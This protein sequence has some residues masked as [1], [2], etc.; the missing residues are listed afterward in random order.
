MDIKKDVRCVK[1]LNYTEFRIFIHNDRNYPILRSYENEIIWISLHFSH[2]LPK[3]A[4]SSSRLL[5]CFKYNKH[6]QDK[7]LT[8][9]ISKMKMDVMEYSG[10]FLNLVLH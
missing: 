7:K 4:A 10:V 3:G 1:P 9:N 6:I 8:I 5:I 2:I